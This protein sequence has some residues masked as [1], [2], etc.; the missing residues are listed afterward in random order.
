LN[1]PFPVVYGYLKTKEELM[2]A[3]TTKRFKNVYV[4]FEPTGVEIISD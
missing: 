3:K 1:A 2:S 4:F